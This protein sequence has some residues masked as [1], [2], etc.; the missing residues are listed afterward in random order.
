MV[1]VMS[2]YA[3]KSQ[4]FQLVAFCEQMRAQFEISGGVPLQPPGSY[5]PSANLAKP[6][7]RELEVTVNFTFF[8][9]HELG[10][11]CST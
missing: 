6:F 5:P 9:T 7:G 8:T 1:S 11:N 2:S 4:D 3:S 10:G